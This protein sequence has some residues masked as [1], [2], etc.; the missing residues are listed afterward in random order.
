MFLCFLVS[1]HI[2]N[3][4]VFVV[5]DCVDLSFFEILQVSGELHVSGEKGDMDIDLWITTVKG[6]VLYHK[7]SSNHGKFTFQ[8][9][10]TNA[11]ENYDYDDDNDEDDT[12]RI[13]IEHQQPASAAHPR[14]TKR[15]VSFRLNHTPPSWAGHQRSGKAALAADTDRLQTT[16]RT[17]HSSL[18]GMIGDLSQLER[19]EKLLTKGVENTTRRVTYLAI[20]SLVVTVMTSA[21]Q[22]TYFKGYFKQ[23]K[24]C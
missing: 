17:M 22:F 10:G 1:F 21:L 23:K 24:I 18:A 11:H 9:P 7:R 20:F 13:C 6:S 3:T 5:R 15:S 19:R 16:M 8:T 12:F 14:G 4:G 2:S